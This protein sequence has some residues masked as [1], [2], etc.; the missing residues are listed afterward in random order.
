MRE[1]R[2][3]AWPDVRGADDL[4]DA[5]L[6]L[7]AVPQAIP[8]D[9]NTALANRLRESLPAWKPLFAELEQTRRAGRAIV[10]DRVYWVATEK[11]KAVAQILPDARLERALPDVPYTATSETEVLVALVQGWMSHSGPVTAAELGAVLGIG[12]E[13]VDE[14]I[15]RLEV[16]GW[17]LRGAFTGAADLEWCERRLLARIHR[18]TLG[19][20]RREI[21]PVTAAEFM[22]WLLDWQHLSPGSQSLGRA[23]HARSRCVS[24]RASRRQRAHGNRSSFRAG[25]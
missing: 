7:L 11:A 16:S 5:L 19:A 2:R 15:L 14:A 6:T 3:Q 21:A 23:G 22:R 13:R 18:L 20:L 17:A 25:S 8:E 10:G 9:V 4:H 1:V 24:F 12:K